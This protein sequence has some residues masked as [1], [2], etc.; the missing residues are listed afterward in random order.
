M[1]F[2]KRKKGRLKRL[3]TF[4]HWLQNILSERKL[5]G[6]ETHQQVLGAEVGKEGGEGQEHLATWENHFVS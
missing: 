6:Q 2:S 3:H 1:H 4:I 5:Q